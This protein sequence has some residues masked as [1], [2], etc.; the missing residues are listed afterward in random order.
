MLPPEP[1]LAGELWLVT[2][3]DLRRTARVRA[4]METLAR[5]LRRERAL[6]EAALAS[7]R[8]MGQRR[9]SQSSTRMARVSKRSSS[10]VRGAACQGSS[11]AASASAW[12]GIVPDGLDLTGSGDFTQKGLTPADDPVVLCMR[13][14]DFD[15]QDL[16]QNLVTPS[17]DG[18][19]SAA[20]RSSAG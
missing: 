10:G 14:D 19:K 2:Q 9:L 13:A 20:G 18:L 17:G 3:P 16:G 7:G 6:L 1:S 4:F 12:S 5:G 15:E 11:I 8:R